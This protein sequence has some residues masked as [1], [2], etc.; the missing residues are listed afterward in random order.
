MLAVQ[1]GGS[2]NIRVDCRN[3]SATGE[4]WR[5]V[6]VF[7]W[8]MYVCV[9]VCVCARVISERKGVFRVP[10]VSKRLVRG[11]DKSARLPNTPLYLPCD[12]TVGVRL[13][14]QCPSVSTRNSICLVRRIVSLCLVAHSLRLVHTLTLTHTL[15]LVLCL[16]VSLWPKPC[17]IE[18]VI[19]KQWFIY[20]ASP[21]TF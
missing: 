5:G 19:K 15:H 7:R 12:P 9:C 13:R 4:S 14:V 10:F 21:L 2:D 6:G 18:G 8:T 11:R 16:Q 20:S 3:H 17:P 1:F